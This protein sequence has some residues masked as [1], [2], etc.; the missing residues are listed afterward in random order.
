MP[1]SMAWGDTGTLCSLG[2]RPHLLDGIMK[3]YGSSLVVT[4]AV[5]A[6]LY[7]MAR[8]PNARR[9]AD[10]RLRCLSAER[11]VR[12]LD[13]GRIRVCPLLESEETLAKLDRVLRKLNMIEARQQER[14]GKM[15]DPF[16]SAPKHTGEAHSIVSAMRTIEHGGTTVFLTNDGGA[17]LVAQHHG[18]TSRHVGH[19]LAELACAD[20]TVT[21]TDLLEHFTVVTSHFATVP[22]DARPSGS[23]FFECRSLN[24]NCSLCV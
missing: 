1:V 5:A 19:L 20:Q 9:T 6:E 3:L 13:D 22:A 15:S 24:G 11:V 10:N 16:R 12:A 7:A 17:S 14:T 4:E 2:H 23:D 18:I 21:A 8:I